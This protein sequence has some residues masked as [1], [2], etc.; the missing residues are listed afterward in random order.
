VIVGDFDVFYNLMK[1][2][3]EWKQR[4][5]DIW[6]TIPL[7]LRASDMPDPFFFVSLWGGGAAVANGGG[8]GG[9]KKKQKKEN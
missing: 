1:V 2:R 5:K 3:K 6:R 8:G 9:T 4:K 7:L